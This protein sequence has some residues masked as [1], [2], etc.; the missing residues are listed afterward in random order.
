MRWEVRLSLASGPLLPVQV[1]HGYEAGRASGL[2]LQLIAELND[3]WSCWQVPGWRGTSN[4]EG[5][6]SKEKGSRG[7]LEFRGQGSAQQA[8][9]PATWPAQSQLPLLWRPL[10]L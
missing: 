1:A 4:G 9:M 10:R 7:E 6:G 8:R 2:R 3:V 5:T